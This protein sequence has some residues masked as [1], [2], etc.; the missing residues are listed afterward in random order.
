MSALAGHP[1]RKMNGL[2]NE[3]VILDLRQSGANV[4]EDSARLIADPKT[5]PGCGL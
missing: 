3:F 4:S 1:Y 5:G 2:G